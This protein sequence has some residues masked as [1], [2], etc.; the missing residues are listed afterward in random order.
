VEKLKDKKEKV[1]RSQREFDD[2]FFPK[3][4]QTPESFFKDLVEKIL[5]QIKWRRK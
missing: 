4:K 1:F 2:Y 3:K 5:S